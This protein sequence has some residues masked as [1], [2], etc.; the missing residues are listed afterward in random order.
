MAFMQMFTCTLTPA[1]CTA[2]VAGQLRVR[3]SRGHWAHS[4]LA[5][6]GARIGHRGSRALST[7]VL[8]AEPVTAVG[9]NYANA[10]WPG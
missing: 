10:M 2:A 9:H 7:A 6:V 3:E 1:H 5:S 8:M 4:I